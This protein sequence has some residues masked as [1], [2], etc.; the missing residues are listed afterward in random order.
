MERSKKEKL[1]FVSDIVIS[2]LNFELSE[3]C[4]ISMSD[5]CN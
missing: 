5:Y 1:N 3:V 4:L 2:F